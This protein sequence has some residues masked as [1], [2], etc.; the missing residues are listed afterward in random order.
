[1]A[2]IYTLDGDTLT[3][4]LQGSDACDEARQAAARIAE[5]R[6]EWVHLVDEDGEWLVPPT[7]SWRD[8]ERFSDR[9]AAQKAGI[10]S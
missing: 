7:G 3:D 9:R 2:A 1:M 6:E 10:P 5:Q 4:G 8:R